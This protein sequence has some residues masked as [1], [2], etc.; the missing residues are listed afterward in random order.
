VLGDAYAPSKQVMRKQT[1]TKKATAPAEVVP[2]GRPARKAGKRSAVEAPAS[3]AAESPRARRATARTG[4]PH[5]VDPGAELRTTPEGALRAQSESESPENYGARP[6]FVIPGFDEET[7][8][9]SA[10][11]HPGF[12]RL[13]QLAA[14][15]GGN[16][17]RGERPGPRGRRR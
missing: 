9:T 3:H 8:A 16:K 17:K 4:R 13:R 14:H 6:A 15:A 10:S 1:A 12:D 7:E 5:H 2:A 11:P